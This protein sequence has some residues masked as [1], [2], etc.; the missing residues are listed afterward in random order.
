MSLWKLLRVG[1]AG[2]ARDRTSGSAA[3]RQTTER[4]DGIRAELES[5]GVSASVSGPVAARLESRLEIGD[6]KAELAATTS[7]DSYE[8]LLDGVAEAL[9]VLDAKSLLDVPGRKDFSPEP[10]LQEIERLM[11]AFVG[12]LSKLDEVLDV[13]NAHVERMRSA[14]SESGPVH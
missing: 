5:R 14:R 11:A 9:R 1:G 6:D 7:V 2:L 10:D 8:L 4:L 12:E 3:A 13:L